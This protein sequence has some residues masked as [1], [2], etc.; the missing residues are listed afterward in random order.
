VRRR[1]LLVLIAV[2]CAAGAGARIAKAG[3]AQPAGSAPN[4]DRFV[5]HS[6][7]AGRDYLIE[8]TPPA[9]PVLAGRNV[10]VVYALDAGY[11][12][13]ASEAQ[14]LEA[15][16]LG[17]LRPAIEARYPVDASRSILLGHSLAGLFVANLLADR[18]RAFRAYLIA[19]PSIWADNETLARVRAAA[20]KGEG[21]LVFLGVGGAETPRMLNGAD[22]LAEALRARPSGFVVR[23]QRFA[24]QTHRSYYPAF[25]DASL[26]SVLPARAPSEALAPGAR[27]RHEAGTPRDNAGLR[28]PTPSTKPCRPPSSR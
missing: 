4:A 10:P 25:L 1:R 11:H 13:A 8:V 6:A 16:I 12:V 23:M 15:F 26:P 24:G 14:A 7:R 17:E 9:Q 5:M 21:R 18:P 22:A 19:S 2:A 27:G 28:W 20:R 3:E